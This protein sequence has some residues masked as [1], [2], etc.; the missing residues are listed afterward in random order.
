MR[1]IA[2]RFGGRRLRAFKA[3]H[4]RPTTDRVKESL[5]SK[6][7]DVVEGARV[8]DLFAGTGS[9]GLEALSRGASSVLAVE[10]HRQSQG[11]IRENVKLLELE[12]QFELRGQDVFKF[13]KSESGPFDLVLIDPPFTKAIAHDAM[14]A[15]AVNQRLLEAEAII[16][17][18]A[19][20][21]ERIDDQYEGIEL[22]DRKDFGDKSLSLFRKI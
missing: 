10:S 2:G 5:F 21:H 18:E 12:D 22:L 7:G 11:I 16:A 6:L 20:K 9:L 13:L 17:I 8:L 1:I 3:G 4:I 19:S 14:E 15:L